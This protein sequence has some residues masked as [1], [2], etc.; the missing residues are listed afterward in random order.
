MIAVPPETTDNIMT[1]IYTQA[2]LPFMGQKRR[3]N[4]AFKTALRNE[5]G[6]CTTFVDLF[7]GSGL[8]SHFTHTVR[9]DAS[10]I[11]NDF[12]NYTGRLAA[13]P[14]T[15]ALLA[16]LRTILHDYP[17]NKRIVEPYRTR[18]LETIARYDRTGYVDYISLSASILFSSNASMIL[19]PTATSTGSPSPARTTATS[20]QNM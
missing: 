15:N 18:V 13:I 7:G 8:L 9:P 10:V 14:A 16:E 2:P 11:Y 4:D 6:D 19:M 17:R 12:D 20:S 3:W 1:K 5:F